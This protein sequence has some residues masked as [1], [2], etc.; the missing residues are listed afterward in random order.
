MTVTKK[1]LV[2][3]VIDKVHF[4]N[5]RNRKGQQFLF[6]ELDY[7]PLT[8]KRATELVNA[9]LEIVKG[10]LERG[11][12]IRIYGFGSFQTRFRWARPGRNPKTGER[13]ILG[14]KHYVAFKVSARLR[15]LINS[16]MRDADRSR[17]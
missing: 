4:M 11:N 7:T 2:N 15:R 3:S 5:R 14:S 8:R 12:D 16:G 17:R 9:T 6:P 13:I 1:D 10:A